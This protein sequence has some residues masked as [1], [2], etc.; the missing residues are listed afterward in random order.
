M[1]QEL[2]VTIGREALVTVLLLAAP[3]LGLSLATGLIVSIF[4]ATTQIHEQTLVF[5]PKI[6][7]VLVAIGIFGEWML[8]QLL[9]YTRRLYAVLP[10]LL[11]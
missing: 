8:T 11:P 1:S 3:A 7:A 6:V 2:V 10:T 5:V 4:Q 9:E